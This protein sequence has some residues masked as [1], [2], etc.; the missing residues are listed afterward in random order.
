MNVHF[1][2]IFMQTL[3]ALF[4]F[5]R[6]LFVGYFYDF[7]GEG[8]EEELPAADTNPEEVTS[9][10]PADGSADVVKPD[11]L[12]GERTASPQ[13]TF[14]FVCIILSVQFSL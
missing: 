2:I 8:Q 5:N 9:E 1:N 14:T 3:N 13:G 10:Q 4:N 12:S 6:C 7:E 11:S